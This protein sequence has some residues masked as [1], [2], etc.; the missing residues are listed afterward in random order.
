MLYNKIIM[1]DNMKPCH[2]TLSDDVIYKD[3]VVIGKWIFTH[4][5]EVESSNFKWWKSY[6][7]ENTNKQ[8]ISNF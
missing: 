4:D 1:R 7:I 8:Y 2:H 6:F 5:N 3:V